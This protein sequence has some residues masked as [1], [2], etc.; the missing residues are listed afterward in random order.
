[1]IQEY[2]LDSEN[3][4][5]MG[6]WL[7]NWQVWSGRVSFGDFIKDEVVYSSQSIADCY[8]WVS[9][10]REGLLLNKN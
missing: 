3:I 8:A 1:M 4:R 10:K 6:G 9:A 2:R 7:C 5:A